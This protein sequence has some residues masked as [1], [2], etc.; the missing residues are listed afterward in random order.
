M[1]PGPWRLPSKLNEGFRITLVPGEVQFARGIQVVYKSMENQL[2]Q[3][4]MLHDK[5]L[6]GSSLE[7]MPR[8]GY[9]PYGSLASVRSLANQAFS[10][11]ADATLIAGNGVRLLED[12]RENYPA[13]LEAIEGAQHHVYFENYII[14]DDE[15]G[16]MFAE[17]FIRKALEGVR[18]RLIYDWLGGNGKASR[19]FWEELRK[20]GVDV[21]C[22]NPPRL[23]SPLGWLSRDHRKMLSVDGAVGFITGLCV[24]NEWAGA[25]D[26]KTAPW[27]DTGVEV[28]G[29]AVTEIE[30]AFA[31]MWELTGDPIPNE[32]LIEL[33]PPAPAG[34]KHLRIIASVPATAGVFRLDQMVASLARE[35]LWLT[36]AYFAGT[37][38]YVQA[39]R[40]AARDG[41]DV[42]LLVPHATDLPLLQPLS[43]AGYRTLLEAGVRVFEWNGTM[44]HA[45]TMVADGRW[46]RVG[47]TNLNIASWLGNAELDAVIEDEAFAHEMEAMYL[48]DLTNATEIV[49]DQRRRLRTPG[50]THPRYTHTHRN[51][52]SAGP[53]AAGALRISNVLGAAVTD[54]RTLEPVEAR[55]MLATGLI[56][57]ILAGVLIFVPFLLVYPVILAFTWIAVTLLM[58]ASK[59][60]A[61]TRKKRKSTS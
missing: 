54:R 17:A 52:G 11:A 26:G 32:E 7:L 49:L 60:Y 10:R 53:A 5:G 33:E 45:K 3:S 39:L 58:K 6:T 55:I 1:V 9:T 47:S 56:L 13:W 14:R 24:G 59:T 51:R 22:Y 61:R 2:K 20:G 21:R 44:L 34:D 31:Q 30:Q 43:R 35:R 25:P 15:T 8:R 29:P 48:K 37:T 40:I 18:V 42:R 28:R 36:D 19:S 57:L 16:R 41:V 50:G 27:R 23:D 46:A 38:I 4:D 12:A